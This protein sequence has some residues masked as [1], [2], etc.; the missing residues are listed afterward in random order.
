MKLGKIEIIKRILRENKKCNDKMYEI[1]VFVEQQK[2]KGIIVL[3][4]R[5]EDTEKEELKNLIENIEIFEI[6]YIEKS[7]IFE[8]EK[9]EYLHITP[10]F[11]YSKYV[12]KRLID[13]VYGNYYGILILDKNELDIKKTYEIKK[14]EY[15]LEYVL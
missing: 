10:N 5:F 15:P 14:Y 1:N 9:S 12:M 3:E 8:Y 4:E 7:R 13:K 2:Y 6:Q 11:F